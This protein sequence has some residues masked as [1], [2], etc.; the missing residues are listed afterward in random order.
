[1]TTET[2]KNS[3]QNTSRNR[4][5]RAGRIMLKTFL[6]IFFLI[7]LVFLL[8]LTPPVQN[9]IRKK[10]VAFLENKLDTRVEVGRIYVGLPRDIVIENVYVEDRQKDT[11]L[12]GGK[13]MADLNIWKLITKNEI[14]LQSVVLNDIT[15]KVRR[16]LPD[17]VYNFQFIIDAFASADTSTSTS[18]QSSSNITLG[19]I[20]LN[21]IRVLYKDVV[22][23]SDMEASLANLFTRISNFDPANS[24]YEI[25]ETR[26]HGLTARVYQ[27]KP[28]ATPE[29]EE[30]DRTEASQAPAMQLNLGSVKLDKINLDYRN[31]VSAFYTEADL[32]T[33]EVN[34]KTFDMSNRVIDLE[35]VLLANTNAKI[36]LGKKAEAKV[37]EKEL[38]QE[39]EVQ[40][41]AGWRIL[42]RSVDI[43]NN[44]LQF[45][46]DNSA[47]TKKGMDYAHLDAKDFNL[48]G[49]DLL[50]ATDTISGNINKA[51]FSEQSGFTLNALRTEFA[52]TTTG[53]YLRDLYIETPGTR[54]QRQAE[55]RYASIDALSRDIGN[56]ELDLDIEGSRVLVKDVLTFV[57]SLQAQ[58]AFAD[59]SA[60]WHL[61]GRITGKVKDLS[62]HSLQVQGLQDTR[63]DIAG[64]IKGLP[65]MKD[66]QADLAIR[67]IRSSR[68]DIT[69][70]VPANSFPKQITLP[71]TLRASGKITGNS[72]RMQ[73]DIRLSTD[74]GN[75]T[76]NG[77]FS[78]F[79]DPSKMGYQAKIETGSIQLGTIL[80][81]KM[82]G[83][84]SVSVT[85]NG[86]GMDLKTANAMF[87]GVIHSAAYNN[88]IYKDVKLDGKIAAQ[89]IDVNIAADDPN[90]DLDLHATTDISGEYPALTLN[91]MIDSIKLEPLHF[92]KDRMVYRGRIQADFPGLDP[93][94]LNGKLY[95]T[96]SVFVYK[97]ERVSLDTLQVLAGRT[98]TGRYVQL[99]SPFM[100]AKMEGQYQLTEIGTVF[101]QAIQPHFSIMANS[102]RSDLRPYN[103]TIDAYVLDNPALKVFVPGLTEMDSV[104]LKARFSNETGWNAHVNAPV[105]EMGA[106][107]LRNLQL[108]AVEEGDSVNINT[109]F[110]RFTSGPSIVIDQTRL[111]AVLRDNQ[112][113]FGLNI[114]DPAEKDKYNI[115]GLI[116]QPEL[117]KYLLS[118]SPDSLILNY[119]EWTVNPNNQLVLSQD[120]IN[121]SQL[122]LGQNGQQLSVNSHS[123]QLNAPMEAN[124]EGFQLSTLTGFVQS[125]STLVNGILDGK[126]TFNEL[127][128]EPVFVG[129][130]YVKDLSLQGDT[131]GNLKIQVD[132]KTPGTYA[133]DIVLNG[134]GNDVR[135]AGNYYLKKGDSQFDFDIDLRQLPMATIAAA[136]GDN[137]RDASGYAQGKFKLG[138][139]IA[140]PD[141]NGDLNFRQ[142]RF[143]FAM[144]NSYFSID[145]EKIRFDRT[146]IHFDQFEIKDSAQN[147]LVVDGLAATQNFVNYNFDMDVRAR[148]FRALNSTKRDNKL[149]YGQLYFNT[150]LKVKGTETAPAIDGRLVI[151]ENTKMTV[152]LPQ[153]D[154]GIVQRE[155]IVEFVDM[156]ATQLDSVLMAP[157][158]SLNTSPFTG[159]DISVNIEINKEAELSLIIDEGNGDFL[160]VKGEA[161][162]TAGIDPSGKINMAGTYE[163]EEGSYELTFNFVRRK[164]N[165]EKGSR[166][167]WEGEPTDATVDLDAIYIANAA[168]LDLVKNQ[169]EERSAFERN[170][171]L[172][173]LPFDVHLKM[174]GEL[175]KPQI[176]FDIILPEDK[177]YAVSGEILTTVRNKLEQLRQETGEMN[178][179]V[180]S[181][182][183]LNRFM[184]EN[185]FDAS[186]E[187]FNAGTFARQSVSKL[188][189]EQ[190]NR[191]ADD[192]IAGVDLNFDVV[193]SDDY[194]TGE[195]RDR[196]DLN[197]GLSK[198]LLNDRLTVTVGSNF[199]LEGPSGAKQQSTNI[200]GDVALDYRISRDNRYMLRAYRK[201]DYQGVIDGYIIETGVGFIITVD[202]NRFRQLFISKRE[203]DQRRERRRKQRELEKQQQEQQ[204]RDSTTTNN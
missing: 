150:N 190:L 113:R 134:R 12:S 55:I 164:F 171:Y 15:A 118:L 145:Q 66:M 84:V 79:D 119:D 199:E 201:N 185:P 72:N 83:P 75:A 188:L 124:F 104:T 192:L 187:G 90:A 27:V 65:S 38:E 89:K 19:T 16:E 10:V 52:Y 101:Q 137:L 51:S 94:N 155:G 77:V 129:D 123:R 114:K 54:L 37:V 53:S 175:L 76:V 97:E 166:I 21:N 64:R 86:K 184:A 49:G 182:L 181:L 45:D 60:V 103:F 116:Q 169:L 157:Y 46:N 115:K 29:P 14:I 140:N 126:I 122:V 112:I 80:Q 168:P 24:I 92:T 6:W 193:S 33:L 70:F 158:D 40:A 61:N 204:S 117:N 108:H 36:R 146:G 63:M 82:L 200:A 130:L 135:V 23:G 20:E 170:T 194:T 141:V 111:L 91:G 62:I 22:S 161:E 127:S 1:M 196:T 56:M 26:I 153:N 34:A 3:S 32:G 30:K 67:E 109:T 159:M 43:E 13:I 18:S 107:H 5:K 125:D 8:V 179:Q 174:E 31:D 7:V 71:A 128:N 152:V 48:S 95:A 85:A 102:T 147:T 151:N 120:G 98:D 133:A 105:L 203:R 178:K 173:K 195:R 106:N 28:L 59:P 99:I 154:P 110:E 88:Y 167:T 78:E 9:F 186:G 198:Q 163:L 73:T 81:N 131:L 100:T 69:R 93:D 44:D 41:E 50:I 143:N 156:D 25:P 17:T 2:G 144:L 47:P 176:S 142:A 148:D 42:V 189:T 202:Y 165:I 11:L 74:L 35:K 39:L 177:K 138:G 160:N 68:R 96:E 58:P 191:L 180:F 57:P 121:A 4:W 162:L 132:N 87:D 139:T 149:F 172:Q 197:V 183:L 136:S